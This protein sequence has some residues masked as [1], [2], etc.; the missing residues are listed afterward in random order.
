MVLLQDL[1]RKP[2]GEIPLRPWSHVHILLV[3][4][5]VYFLPWK[6]SLSLS[7][8]VS[9]ALELEGGVRK[10]HYPIEL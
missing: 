9:Q 1:P 8:P 5:H 6:L 2:P 4:G 3:I 10:W 7:N